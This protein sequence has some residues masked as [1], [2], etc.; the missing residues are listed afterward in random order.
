MCR[1]A[2]C[3]DDSLVVL[4]VSTRDS[5]LLSDRR[6]QLNANNDT[7]SVRRRTGKVATSSSIIEPIFDCVVFQPS[8]LS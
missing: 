7:D 6:G 1:T 2:G 4:H 3:S 5:C 8:K